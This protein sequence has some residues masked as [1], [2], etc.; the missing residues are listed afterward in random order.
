[1]ENSRPTQQ[2]VSQIVSNHAPGSSQRTKAQKR[3]ACSF[4]YSVFLLS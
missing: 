1:V 4:Q 3:S 2:H